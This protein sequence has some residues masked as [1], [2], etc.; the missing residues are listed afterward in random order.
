[1]NKTVAHQLVEIL[2]DAQVKRIYGIVGD[3]L[4]PITNALHEDGRM[5]WIHMRH[6]ESGAF[7]A[8]AEAQITGKLAVCCGS[9]GP[10]NL[11][12]INGL[13]DAQQSHAPVLAMASHIPLSEVGTDY[14]QETH[15]QILF[16]GC[17]EYCELISLP[18]QAPRI[19]QQAMTSALGERGVG[20][21]VLSGDVAGEKAKSQGF[22]YPL[23]NTPP[24][25]DN[26]PP[27][28]SLEVLAQWMAQSSGVTL[29]CGCGCAESIEEVLS[30]AEEVQAPVAYTFRGK[31]YFETQASPYCVGMTGLLGWGDAY[32]A[33]HSCE[34]LVLLGTDF[35]YDMFLPQSSEIK[36][37]QVDIHPE[38]IGRRCPV[39]L[40]IVGDVGETVRALLPL[41]KEKEASNVSFK[42][43]RSQFLKYSQ[44]R[45]LKEEQKA[46]VY[47]Q[48]IRGLKVI[49]PEYLV[50]ELSKIADQN[51]IFTVDTGTP[52]I[53]AARYLRGSQSRRIIGSFKHGS[54]ACAL[55]M[56]IGAQCARPE[57]QVIAL[58]GDGGISMCFGE[59]MTLVQYKLPIKVIVFN[60]R[61]LDFIRLEMEA[62]GFVPR[63][64]DL[65]NPSFAKVAQAM[66]LT[67]F[68]LEKPDD[69]SDTL[70]RFL[71]QSG[72]ALLEVMV[73]HHELALPSHLSEGEEKGFALSMVKQALSGGMKTVW[74]TLNDNRKLLE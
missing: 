32:E 54:M 33:M 27:K 5:S 39:Q 70:E 46:N 45:Y 48:Y 8:S 63:E 67:G 65:K 68:L 10:G 20:V 43:K 36:I 35:P 40:G 31:E 55:P 58:C 14:F 52:D 73:D 13:Y 24:P 2:G 74:Q 61:S 9:S 69:V 17:S 25:Q 60:N 18:E 37:V 44:E 4:N 51:A 23:S 47:A 22:I 28:A 11:H 6:E 30:L 12:L 34:L 56:S 15:P 64:V 7:A 29:F 62:A 49:R 19:I 59:L 16:Q 42:T 41:L 1:M 71:N 50:S 53:W 57:C 66:G 21:F 38:R 3:S 26:A 72:P